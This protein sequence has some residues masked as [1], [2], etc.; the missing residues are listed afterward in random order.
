[1]M[2]RIDHAE[3]QLLRACLPV[4]HGFVAW[5][6]Q[7]G[8]IRSRLQHVAELIGMS[9]A[10]C[11]LLPPPHCLPPHRLPLHRLSPHRLSLLAVRLGALALGLGAWAPAL[12]AEEGRRF[13]P[14]GFEFPATTPQITF[15][16]PKA[17]APGRRYR[18]VW[19]AETAEEIRP[20][21]RI[22]AAEITPGDLPVLIFSI[23]RPRDD[24]PRGLYRLEIYADERLAHT[25]RFVIR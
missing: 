25:E 1:M 15:H 4:L 8:S 10:P 14:E 18:G 23:T 17:R 2:S 7:A 24:W 19:I 21:F 3:R 22:D 20:D 6:D 16:F 12:Q 5:G 9:P 13:T 11:P